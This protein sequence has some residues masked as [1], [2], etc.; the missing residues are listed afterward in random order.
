MERSDA[1]ARQGTSYRWQV[2]AMLWLV[3][4]FNYAD[5]Q[6]IY[7]VFPLLE[8]EFAFDKVQL[9]LIGSAFMWV[10]LSAAPVFGLLA[11]RL[12]QR[13]VLLVNL[14][15]MLGGAVLSIGCHGVDQMIV[16]RF[17]SSRSLRDAQ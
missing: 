3:C 16:L 13:M 12:N 1:V 7:A 17:L 6:A 2:V 8:Q 5:R 4:F 11:D 9:G 10:Y 15:V 14:A